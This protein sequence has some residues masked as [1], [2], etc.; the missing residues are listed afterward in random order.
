M[1][2]LRLEHGVEFRRLSRE[3]LEAL[4]ALGAAVGEVIQ[5]SYD[6][7]DDLTRRIWDSYLASRAD[8]MRHLR[9]NEQAFLN[10]RTLEFPFPGPSI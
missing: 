3:I 5:E 9:F 8:T 7:G 4:G 2:V 1:E 6:A 10:A